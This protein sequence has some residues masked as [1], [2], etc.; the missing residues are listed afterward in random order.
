FADTRAQH[1][2]DAAAL[3]MKPVEWKRTSTA[4]LWPSTAKHVQVIALNGTG[5]GERYVFVVTDGTKLVAIFRASG[6]EVG[7]LHDK[8]ASMT[9]PTVNSPTVDWSNGG[10]G[11]PIGPLPQPGGP[12]GDPPFAERTMHVIMNHAFNM[13]EQA[14]QLEAELAAQKR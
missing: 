2:A 1:K 13:N 10:Q 5:K 7:A 3:K 8:I 4:A 6:D 14:T 9:R 12:P 11:T